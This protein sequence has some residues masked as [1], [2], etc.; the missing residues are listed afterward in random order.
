[1]A[2]R[3]VTDPD[4]IREV[5]AQAAKT[6][7]TGALKVQTDLEKSMASNPRLR[8]VTD[9][10]KLAQ[11]KE[12]TSAAPTT[13]EEVLYGL[14][15]GASF[16]ENS[17][18][19]A[20]AGLSGTGP[21]KANV[22]NYLFDVIRNADTDNF[23][24][25]GNPDPSMV[26][27]ETGDNARAL[28][29]ERQMSAWGVS[30]A[31]AN[32]P[33]LQGS[34]GEIAG[35][36]G[37]AVLDPTTLVSIAPKILGGGYFAAMATGAGIAGADMAMYEAAEQGQ[38]DPK[39]V[40]LAMGAG[41][42]LGAGVLWAGRTWAEHVAARKALNEPITPDDLLR[43]E[44]IREPSLNGSGKELVPSGGPAPRG[45]RTFEGEFT[46]E[47]EASRAAEGTGNTPHTPRS[48][49]F[50]GEFS[51]IVR[52]T[53]E[54]RNKISYDLH[55]GDY[56]SAARAINQT[57]K[58]GFEPVGEPGI[59]GKTTESTM[60]QAKSEEEIQFLTKAYGIPVSSPKPLAEV[61]ASPSR[62]LTKELITDEREVRK[63]MRLMQQGFVGTQ[64]AS[65]LAGAGIGYLGGGA[66]GAIMGAAIGGALPYGAGWMARRIGRGSHK[67]PNPTQSTVSDLDFVAL[68]G[69]TVR[70]P[71][72]ILKSKMGKVGRDFELAMREAQ[73]R[74]E[75]ATAESLW[76]AD[77]VSMNARKNGVSKEK[78][79]KAEFDA[80]EILQGIKS[81]GT[82]SS[83]AV[84]IADKWATQFSKV[85]QDARKSGVLSADAA[86]R[87][88]TLAKAKGYWPRVYNEAFLSTDEGKAKWA[89]VFTKQG[90]KKNILEATLRSILRDEKTVN[91][92]IKKTVSKNGLLYIDSALAKKM[93]EARRKS[94][95]VTRSGH[96][97]NN[98]A[99]HVASESILKPFLINDPKAVMA[100][101]FTDVEKRIAYA[102]RFGADDHGALILGKQLQDKYGNAAARLAMETYWQRVGD[103]RS[104]MV[105]AAANFSETAATIM[106]RVNAYETLKLALAQIL[107]VTQASVLGTVRLANVSGSPKA[108][109]RVW[110]GMISD[111]K[112]SPGKF[113]ETAARSGA[114]LETSLMQ[115]IG[116]FSS[117]EHRI[118]GREFTGK[119]AFLENFNNPTKFLEMTQFVNAEKMQ[120]V[121]GSNMGRVYAE[122]LMDQYTALRAAGKSTKTV[123]AQMDEIR[124]DYSKDTFTESDVLDAAL[125]WSDAVNF[126][127]TPGNMPL[128]W[129]HPTAAWF[130]KFKVF[131]FN[132][133]SFAMD[134]VIL[135]A[136]KAET[137]GKKAGGALSLATAAG[138]VGM[139]VDSL[140]RLLQGD[141][142]DYTLTQRYVRGIA[143]LGG[144]G[145]WW[146]VANSFDPV[147]ALAGPVASDAKTLVTEVKGM[148]GGKDG[149]AKTV[150]DI[151]SK[152]LVVPFEPQL[153]E[154][155]GVD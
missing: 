28:N 103:S 63:A 7:I 16:V 78:I 132:Y 147:T 130:R 54:L 39:H 82:A 119:M 2:L 19:V 34:T 6:P 144:L 5:S 153:K 140:R 38:I 29:K 24:N 1:M 44:H 136:W 10:K 48:R 120:R 90:W 89:E 9:P 27:N 32:V 150:S 67:A 52:E 74:A 99:V 154:A 72:A 133:A 126:R 149:P 68:Q 17:G 26:E 124:L 100:S 18:K 57:L 98:R 109:L 66:D 35:W 91:D 46:V 115:I 15:T 107:N 151:L 20:L 83:A 92:I 152:S 73:E 118:A 111:L 146:D 96:L 22:L 93:L 138:V 128:G 49:I 12:W 77:K 75:R 21:E 36:V 137:L 142:K 53:T 13:A 60:W 42:V 65:T 97:E 125:R 4:I 30:Q 11:I 131:A 110:G 79:R 116:E 113:S 117:V 71:L 145:L 69:W 85:L 76:E 94:H 41:A 31:I 123:E 86:S 112:N 47:G 25:W 122:I 148:F 105:R 8:K 102:N 87:L 3:E 141:D 14:R 58:L 143:T 108:I 70:S 104:E 139:P 50:E 127:N 51:E 45:G 33:D 135:P 101:Y 106:G 62:N 121:I 56:E 61:S 134:N 55:M 95:K 80:M 88:A 64:M 84:K 23:G 37:A 40:G 155:I 43:I 114:A 81:R 129:A 59:R